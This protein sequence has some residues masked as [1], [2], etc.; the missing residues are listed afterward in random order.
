MNWFRR[1]R[2][3]NFDVKDIHHSS[4]GRHIVENID[5]IYQKIEENCHV[6]NYD[7]SKE[8]SIDHK[9]VLELR[10]AGYTKKL[11]VWMLHDLTVKNLMDLI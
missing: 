9:T 11:D 8:L 7:I 1:F 10:K 4:Y 6:S 5:E 2:H 3:G